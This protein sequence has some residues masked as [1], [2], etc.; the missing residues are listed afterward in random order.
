MTSESIS[1]TTK[2][3]AAAEAVFSVLADPRN[4]AP[5]DGA[6]WVLEA[7]DRERLTAP[8]Q[9]FRMAMYHP[10]HPN[11]RYQTADRVRVF[12]RPHAI[13]WEPGYDMDD[14]SLRFDGWVWRYDLTPVDRST[15]E[16]T[17]SYDWSA[18]PDSIREDIGC[19]P[20]HPKHLG[21]SLARL[22]SLVTA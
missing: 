13:S 11:R 20:F 5:I 15:T 2:I 1:A 18:V 4:H 12:D 8:G 17:L 9:I 3:K 22:A 6:N 14:G 7:L 10:K 16:V 21:N 19:P